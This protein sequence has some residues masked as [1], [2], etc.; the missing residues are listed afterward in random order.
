MRPRSWLIVGIASVAVVLLVGRAVTTLVVDHAWYVA[1]GAPAL[2]WERTID[3]AILQGSAGLA[4]TLFAFANLYAVRK[5]IREVAIP[6]R[7]A[8]I[9]LTAMVPGRRLLLITFALATLIGIGLAAPLTDWTEVAMARHGIAFGEIEGFLDRDLGF[10]VYLLPLEETV[11]IWALVS[12]V[13]VGTVV[14]VLYALTRSLRLDGRRVSASTHA[15]RHLSALGALVMLLFAWSYRLDGFDLLRNGTGPDGLFGRVDHIIALRADLVLTVICSLGALLLLRAGWLGQL[16]LSFVT[17]SIVLGSALGFRHVLP[18]VVARTTLL[19]EP[20]R[21]DVDYL[22]TRT[23][24]SR[25]AYDVDAIRSTPPESL[26]RFSTR[27]QRNDLARSVSLWDASALQLH[28]GD[29]SRNGLMPTRPAWMA[30]DNATLSALVVRRPPSGSERWS[31]ALIDATQPA[32]RDSVIELASDPPDTGITTE[33]VVAPGL[34]GHRLFID[35]TGNILGTPLRTAALR[36]A[37]AWAAR[38]PDMLD[39]G[40][41]GDAAPVYVAQRDV[42]ERVALLAPAFVQGDDVLPLL[43]DGVLYWTLN[44]YSASGSFPLSQDWQIAGEVRSYFKFAAT[45]VVE[46]ATGRVRLIGATR[47]DPIAKTWLAMFP[48]L[49][50]TAGELPAGMIDRL[51]PPTESGVAQLRTFARYGSRFEGAAQRHLP[52][53]AFA[54]DGPPS[55]LLATDSGSVVAWSVPL[56]DAGEQLSGIISVVGGRYRGTFWDTTATPR[57]RWT[58]LAEPLRVA[59]D[60][61]RALL[62][63]GNRREPRM[64]PTRV[65]VVMTDRGPLL[66]QTLQWNRADGSAVVSRVG[67]A[68]DGHIGIGATV[69]EASVVAGTPQSQLRGPAARMP[70]SS[71]PREAMLS[72]LYEAMRQGIRSGNWTRFGVAFDS[73]GRALGKP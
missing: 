19:G 65:Q 34:R 20:A 43:H 40:V 33:P 18:A 71:E 30:N 8:N 55:H 48:E 22:A 17:L 13:A 50:A 29:E 46:S 26:P 32:I 62:P 44:L 24:V 3:T 36:V 23:L 56:L 21:R 7:V 16:R 9:E 61:A 28:G 12:V 27:V 11:Y 15:R 25:R 37:H 73:L 38:D 64:R 68:Y 53:S 59:L 67:V 6:A 70:L 54:G 69:G 45:A 49:Y 2:W 14:I 42:R 57:S 58:T 10:Y 5:T 72:R 4:G 60:S 39:P 52:D 51:P 1:M 66:S 35:P 31:V 47:S 63:D 41:D